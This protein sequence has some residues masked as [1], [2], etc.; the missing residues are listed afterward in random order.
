M[1]GNMSISIRSVSVNVNMN[2]NIFKR[3]VS[4]LGLLQYWVCLI[5]EQ[6]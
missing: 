2:T 1:N 4:E 3:Y 6:T 5:S